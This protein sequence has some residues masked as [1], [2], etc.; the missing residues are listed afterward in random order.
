MN[1]LK[2]TEIIKITNNATKVNATFTDAVGQ[3]LTLYL[4][5]G[6]GEYA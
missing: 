3:T 4:L 1:R 5:E 6:P 2:A